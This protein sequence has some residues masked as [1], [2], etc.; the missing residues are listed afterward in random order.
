MV[1][2]DDM[3]IFF[4]SFGGHVQAR[5]SNRDR[6]HQRGAVGDVAV[7]EHGEDQKCVLS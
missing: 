6:Q 2:G 3:I 1:E 5:P 7:C 4:H